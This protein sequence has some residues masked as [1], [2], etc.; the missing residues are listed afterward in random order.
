MRK[1]FL[2]LREFTYFI[3]NVCSSLYMDSIKCHHCVRYFWHA[4]RRSALCCLQLYISNSLTHQATE[5]CSY[6]STEMPSGGLSHIEGLYSWGS[7]VHENGASLC[8]GLKRDP[9]HK[10]SQ[11]VGGGEGSLCAGAGVLERLPA[12]ASKARSCYCSF[13]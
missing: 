8:Q 3:W 10:E 13:D 4:F 9:E 5:F 12:G 6:S 11:A 2:N 1:K 7:R